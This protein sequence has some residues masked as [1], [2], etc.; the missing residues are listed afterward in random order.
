MV[1]V[2]LVEHF[3][4]THSSWSDFSIL[5]LFF[6]SS[7]QVFLCPFI[8]I[9]EECFVCLGIYSY[10]ISFYHPKIC[11]EDQTELLISNI[12]D[13]EGVDAVA[14]DELPQIY[15]FSHEGNIFEMNI[16]RIFCFHVFFCTLLYE[17][18]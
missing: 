6:F 14:S 15:L 10:F 11:I 12:F 9:S 2:L 16:I 13:D 3:S 18:D 4:R 17:I 1:V 7:F 8:N 5:V